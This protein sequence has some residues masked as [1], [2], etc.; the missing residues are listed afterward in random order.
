MKQ[1]SAGRVSEVSSLTTVMGW[2]AWL[3]KVRSWHQWQSIFSASLPWGWSVGEVEEGWV[4]RGPYWGA[5]VKEVAPSG[6]VFHC[7]GE[8]MS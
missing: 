5:V 8:I 2:V 3:G 7:D 1:K 6:G 4:E